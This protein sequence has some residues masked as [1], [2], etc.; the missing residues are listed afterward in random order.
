MILV[1][2]GFKFPTPSIEGH[3]HTDLEETV[4]ERCVNS[5]LEYV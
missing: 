5:G 1:V 3:I 2:D 4:K